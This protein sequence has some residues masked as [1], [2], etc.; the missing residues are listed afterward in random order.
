[1]S[2]EQFDYESGATLQAEYEYQHD[3]RVPFVTMVKYQLHLD[4]RSLVEQLPGCKV[5]K[6]IEI[7][8]CELL[9]YWIECPKEA[10]QQ[11]NDMAFMTFIK[12]PEFQ[13]YYKD[14][15]AFQKLITNAK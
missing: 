13:K 2:Q 6:V 12:N 8:T 14:S 7:K 9:Q 11:I 10:E 15:T 1:M 4:F 5:V 3:Y